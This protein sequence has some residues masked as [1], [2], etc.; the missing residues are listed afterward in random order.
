MTAKDLFSTFPLLVVGLAAA[1]SLI[2]FKYNYPD[3]L[4]KLSLLW[5]VNFLVDLA[6]HI[7]KYFDI[8]NHWLYN[9]YFW[10]MYLVLAWLYGSVIQDPYVKKSVKWFLVL[11]PLL[12]AADCIAF[13]I[14]TLQTPVVV[15]GGVFMI[16]LAAA[17][18]RELY[19]SDE[20]EP[21]S[22]DPW[23]WF[24]FGFLIHFGGTIPF[25][26]ML[27]YLWEHY[28]GF[29]SFYYL[30]FSNTFTILLNI[31]IITGFLCR[32]NYQKSR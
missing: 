29:T 16:C 23:F 13:G 3:T 11:F 27:N 31:L 20:N 19:M 10:I 12:I 18:F 7:T 9:C 6:G 30:Y 22:R 17:Y 24:S 25:L 8:K 5:V 2:S 15:A 21:I 32:I 1:T 28:R 14:T 4:K 26:G